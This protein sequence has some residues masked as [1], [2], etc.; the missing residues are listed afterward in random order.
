MFIQVAGIPQDMPDRT[1]F[2]FGTVAGPPKYEFGTDGVL[3]GE[4]LLVA[5]V[6]VGGRAYR[7]VQRAVVNAG[8]EN[9]AT[10]KLE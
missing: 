2:G 7:G 4:Y 8:A 5:T 1:Q 10:L 9:Q 3:L 6:A